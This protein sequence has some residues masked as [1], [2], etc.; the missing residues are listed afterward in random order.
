M[1]T[2][3]SGDG[4]IVCHEVRSDLS[5]LESKH[6]I[7]IPPFFQLPKPQQAPDSVTKSVRH[8]IANAH[9]NQIW[10]VADKH[11]VVPPSVKP[12]VTVVAVVAI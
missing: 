6:A 5:P 4:D 9:S 10:G 2:A 7:H 12:I 3:N 1:C 11:L 8:S